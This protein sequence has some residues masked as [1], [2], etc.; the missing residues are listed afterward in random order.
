MQNCLITVNKY[1]KPKD[2]KTDWIVCIEIF[3]WFGI[4]VCFLFFFLQTFG[5]SHSKNNLKN[6]MSKYSSANILKGRAECLVWG[7]RQAEFQQVTNQEEIKSYGKVWNRQVSKHH[8]VTGVKCKCLTWCLPF[9]ICQLQ[10]GVARIDGS[11]QALGNPWQFG[12]WEERNLSAIQRVAGK[13]TCCGKAE[14][15]RPSGTSTIVTI[16]AY[17]ESSELRERE[18]SW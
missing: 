14:V 6:R 1:L 5:F 17:K 3:F 4:F 2:E 11:L 16:P 10:Q 18:I 8:I 15:V 12:Q 7:I 9:N 13:Q